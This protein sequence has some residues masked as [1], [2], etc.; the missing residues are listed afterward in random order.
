MKAKES[1]GVDKLDLGLKWSEPA[2]RSN[3]GSTLRIDWKSKN[4]EQYALYF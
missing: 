3:I 2:F 4:P 1:Q